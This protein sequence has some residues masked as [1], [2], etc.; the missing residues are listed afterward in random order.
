MNPSSDRI[1]EFYRGRYSHPGSGLT[2]QQAWQ[3]N[4]ADLALH[5]GYVHWLFPLRKPSNTYGGPTI[6]EE[7]IREFRHDPDLRR[8]ILKSLALML[9]HY[10]FRLG[11]AG[12]KPAISPAPDFAERTRAWLTPEN[13]EL[14]SM[15]R[16]LQS[17]MLLGFEE[18]ARLFLDQLLA[19]NGAHPG[20]VSD[21]TF[22]LWHLS[23]A[24]ESYWGSAS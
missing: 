15:S 5:R 19:V 10:G 20:V 24:D 1:V 11:L 12:G 18:L 17:L 7:G 8:G 16:I 4:E 21:R 6:T 14:R 13:P 9:G 22:R 23:V 3:W 2:I